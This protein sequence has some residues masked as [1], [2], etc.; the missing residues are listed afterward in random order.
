MAIL[1][2]TSRRR[3][4]IL[5]GLC[6]TSFIIVTIIG[7]SLRQHQAR[8]QAHFLL[9][10]CPQVEAEAHITCLRQLLQPIIRDHPNKIK[11]IFHGIVLLGYQN[12]L[13]FDARWYGEL[14]HKVGSGFIQAHY[15]LNET[16][17]YCSPTFKQGCI[18]GAVM[19]QAM[20]QPNIDATLLCHELTPTQRQQDSIYLNCL[21]GVG[22][23][24][25]LRHSSAIFTTILN[26]C[27]IWPSLLEQQA[28]ASG[29]MMEY[30]V[31]SSHNHIAATT[32]IMELPCDQLSPEWQT[33]CYAA[34]G[35]YR[36]YRPDGEP[37]VTSYEWCQQLP[38]DYQASCWQG[39][40]ERLVLASSGRRTT[41]LEKCD[42]IKT[43]GLRDRCKK[44]VQQWV[45]RYWWHDLLL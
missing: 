20:E 38:D 18:H 2:L 25:M 28:C 34:A 16:I 43:M 1:L 23:S 32:E 5:I 44:S 36:Q 42:Q 27:L 24:L 30:M 41:T 7:I 45:W 13:P 6:L 12:K 22:H 21:H 17:E 26:D 8:T 9:A 37:F 10:H 33:L 35:S 40:S 14:V 15:S 29:V 3:L 31:Q 39:V 11:P 19:Q 4:F